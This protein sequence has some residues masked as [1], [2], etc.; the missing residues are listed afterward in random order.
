MFSDA[1]S[2]SINTH[3][4]RVE[5]RQP[6]SSEERFMTALYSGE[7]GGESRGASACLRNNNT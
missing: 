4:A 1:D 3:L 7:R 2:Y 5:A 6:W